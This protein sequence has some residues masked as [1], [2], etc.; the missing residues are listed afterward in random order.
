MIAGSTDRRSEGVLELHLQQLGPRAV[1]P[2]RPGSRAGAAR[3]AAPRGAVDKAFPGERLVIPAGVLQVRSNDT[4]Y[5]FRPHSAFAHLT[6]LGT[7]REPDAV[8]VLEPR[9]GPATPTAADGGGTDGRSSTSGRGPGGT[10]R[11][12]TP[13]PGTASCGSAS[14]RAWRRWRPS[15]GSSARHLD[16]L[17]DSG[18][19]GLGARRAA[20][21]VVRGADPDLADG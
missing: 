20:V 13:T 11:S 6:G 19:Q 7:D 15:P 18:A 3:R 1:T 14:G 17:P 5:R 12:S 21:R 8:L 16:E 4:D 2:C 9:D 10:P